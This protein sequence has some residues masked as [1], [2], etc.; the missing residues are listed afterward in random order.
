MRSGLDSRL[1]LHDATPLRGSRLDNATYSLAPVTTAY[2]SRHSWRDLTTV[3][4][5]RIEEQ[6]ARA[7]V[8]MDWSAR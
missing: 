8:S 5:A 2:S 6:S 3:G 4:V 1:T 7:P